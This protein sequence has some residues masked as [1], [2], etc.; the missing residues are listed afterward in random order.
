M[1]WAITNI[2]TQGVA[3]DA[4]QVTIVCDSSSDVSDLPT[5][6]APGSI[7]IVADTGSPAYMLNASGS[8]AALQS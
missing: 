5:G 8:W 4:A 7:A 3:G 6:Y 1:A 2:Q